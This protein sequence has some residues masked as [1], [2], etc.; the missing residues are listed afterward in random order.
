M[1]KDIVIIYYGRRAWHSL[2]FVGKSISAFATHL[3]AQDTQIFTRS[4]RINLIK[5][6]RTLSSAIKNPSLGH[7]RRCASYS[8]DQCVVSFWCIDGRYLADLIQGATSLV[9]SPADPAQGDVASPLGPTGVFVYSFVN[10]TLTG[11]KNLMPADSYNSPQDNQLHPSN[12]QGTCAS[13]LI[14]YPFNF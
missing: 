10:A 11:P 1:L 13:T 3:H 5:D 7:N 14:G 6:S 9:P 4:P 2:G 12:E 8:I